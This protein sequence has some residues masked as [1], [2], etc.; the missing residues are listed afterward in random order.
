VI[1]YF[2]DADG[3]PATS[4]LSEEDII[5]GPDGNM[6][7]ID[8]ATKAIDRITV[9]L[10]PKVTTGAASAIGQLTATVAGTVKS[11]RARCRPAG[12]PRR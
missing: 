6:W 7:F 4:D 12:R 1:T 5:Q 9:Q 8:R 3:L 10:P 2:G 11:P